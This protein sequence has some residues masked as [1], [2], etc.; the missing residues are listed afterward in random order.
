MIKNKPSGSI[1]DE[2]GLH[3]ANRAAPATCRDCQ[4]RRTAVR[5]GPFGRMKRPVSGCETAHIATRCLP[6]HCM[7]RPRLQSILTM[8]AGRPRWFSLIYK[9]S[10]TGYVA[11]PH[12]PL[13]RAVGTEVI[14]LSAR[15]VVF[16]IHYIKVAV[17][18][19]DDYA[20][21]QGY[22]RKL[23]G[24]SERRSQ[25]LGPGHIDYAMP[26]LVA[27]GLIAPL[28]TDIVKR[29]ADDAKV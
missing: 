24:R 1:T 29:V 11:C 22:L 8:A 14:E 23:R 13:K 25:R 26:Y 5:Q 21:R 9:C 3:G 17:F 27:R 7:A 19:V 16:C 20:I 10:M 18:G 4:K 28:Y 2:I 15:Q 12:T 6:A